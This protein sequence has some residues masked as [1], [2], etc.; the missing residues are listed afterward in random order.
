MIGGNHMILHDVEKGDLPQIA[1][2]IGKKVEIK[3]L[4]GRI[5]AITEGAERPERSR[6]RGR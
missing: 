5:G 4:D 2:I 6:G 1:A 3:S